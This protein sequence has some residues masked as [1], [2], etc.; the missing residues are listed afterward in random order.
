MKRTPTNT[1]N[2]HKTNGKKGLKMASVAPTLAVA[3]NSTFEK[4]VS[5]VAKEISVRVSCPGVELNPPPITLKNINIEKP[6]PNHIE[7]HHRS[8]M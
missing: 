6:T 8:T 3:G 2:F 7:K 5:R 1:P 4:K